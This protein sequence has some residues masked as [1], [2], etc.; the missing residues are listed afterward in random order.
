MSAQKNCLHEMN[1]LSTHNIGFDLDKIRKLIHNWASRCDFGAYYGV[2][3]VVLG[4]F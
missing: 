3:K 4:G 1:L 2:A